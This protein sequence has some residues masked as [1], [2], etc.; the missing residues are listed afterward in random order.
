[1]LTYLI[2]HFCENCY[3]SVCAELS[4]NNHMCQLPVKLDKFTK[5]H[6]SKT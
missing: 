5:S 6:K 1:M 4:I 2:Y 3:S